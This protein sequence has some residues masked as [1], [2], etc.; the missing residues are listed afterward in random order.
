MFY[1]TPKLFD[2]FRDDQAVN[3]NIDRRKSSRFIQEK[4]YWFVV[5]PVSPW[6]K[7]HVSVLAKN[8]SSDLL[9]QK[10]GAIKEFQKLARD[11]AQDLQKKYGLPVVVF[12]TGSSSDKE[13]FRFEILPV[14]GDFYAACRFLYPDWQT[15]TSIE[16][17]VSSQEENN[18][19]FLG[20]YLEGYE[21]FCFRK[22]LRGASSSFFKR[23]YDATEKDA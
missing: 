5:N 21:C 8:S 15:E 23:I 11:I 2:D 19:Y 13:T 9:K 7:G 12:C 20:F 10:K 14:Q 16:K 17:L 4:K 18:Y 1:F 22:A 6:R 3:D